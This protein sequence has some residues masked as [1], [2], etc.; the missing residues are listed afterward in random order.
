MVC[1]ELKT[2][3]DV[4]FRVRNLGCDLRDLVGVLEGPAPV[5]PL[6]GT[7]NKI[8]RV[9]R[10]S[11]SAEVS[12]LVTAYEH[13]DYVRAVFCELID[14][15]FDLSKWKICASKWRHILVTDARTGFDALSAETLPSDR[16]IAIDVS[17]ERA[18]KANPDFLIAAVRCARGGTTETVLFSAELSDEM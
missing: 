11:M 13:G 16:K 5:C 2:Q 10:C 15:T 12:S 6:E 9:V 4:V 17:G 18:R 1:V 3:E 14:S 7:S 8:H